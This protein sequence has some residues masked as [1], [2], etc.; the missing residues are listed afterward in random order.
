MNEIIS[1]R[2]GFIVRYALPILAII[3]TI[4][5]GGAYFI[6]YPEIVF[7]KASLVRSSD[8]EG[9]FYAECTIKRKYFE[10]LKGKDSIYLAFR[11]GLLKQNVFTKMKFKILSNPKEDFRIRIFLRT[12]RSIPN[13]VMIVGTN[14]PV[15][16]LIMTGDKTLKEIIF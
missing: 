16:I 11:R 8:P 14:E 6:R 3:V 2:P 10:K 1:C 5:I 4:V 12:G 9:A 13:Q 15:D 7:T